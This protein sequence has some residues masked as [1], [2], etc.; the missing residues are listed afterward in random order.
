M[1]ESFRNPLKPSADFTHKDCRDRSF[2]GHDL[3]HANFEEAD[4]RGCDFRDADLDGAIFKNA[5]IGRTI[6]QIGMVLITTLLL[7]LVSFQAFSQLVFAGLGIT[8]DDPA[9]AYVLVLRSMLALAGAMTGFQSWNIS[10]QPLRRWMNRLAVMA[11]CAVVG[12]FYG[13]RVT[14]NNPYGAIAVAV[15]FS[16][17]GLWTG[18]KGPRYWAGGFTFLGAIA[19]YGFC[20]AVGTTVSTLIHAGHYR[21]GMVWGGVCLVYVKLTLDSLALAN[22]RMIR[23]MGTCFKSLI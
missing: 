19:S 18:G 15:V 21:S 23:A 20:F 13:A 9:W 6:R 1:S 11:V 2:R 10:S 16:V 14:Q 5:T 17:A 4:I 3:R 22:Q 8:Q 7:L 12:F